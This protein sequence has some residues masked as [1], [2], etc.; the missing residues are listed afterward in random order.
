MASRL[1]I[2]ADPRYTSLTP[3]EESLLDQGLS[4]D[5]IIRGREEAKRLIKAPSQIP[6]VEAGLQGMR[7]GADSYVEPPPPTPGTLF[8]AVAPQIESTA[9]VVGA[10]ATAAASGL[11]KAYLER[12]GIDYAM[13]PAAGA[14]YVA[15]NVFQALAP[16]EYRK[17]VD[18]FQKE[19]RQSFKEQ[20][21][22]LIESSKKAQD[23]IAKLKDSPFKQWLAQ[24]VA[25]AASNA[26]NYA[27][28]LGGSLAAIATRSP[29][30]V[31]AVTKSLA[32]LPAAQ[33]YTSSY[34][35]AVNEGKDDEFAHDYALKQ[36]GLEYLFESTAP[37]ASSSILKTV[38]KKLG[39]EVLSEAGTEGLQQLTQRAILPNAAPE[40]A[41]EA[42]SQIGRAASGALFGAGPVVALTAPGESRV[43]AQRRAL[44]EADQK[45]ITDKIDAELGGLGVSD[46]AIRES[47][48]AATEL[49]A[50]ADAEV[51]A[52]V[53]GQ[54]KEQSEVTQ[55]R[56][57]EEL[58]EVVEAPL[59][60]PQT[61]P[62]IDISQER[63]DN[64]AVNEQVAP[65]EV[66]P[67]V[68]Q[69]P[70]NPAQ[71]VESDEAE[72]LTI[73]DRIGQPDLSQSERDELKNRLAFIVTGAAPVET[74]VDSTRQNDIDKL[75]A[76]LV[77]YEGNLKR[78]KMPEARAKW[79]A[80]IEATRS[81]LS[82]LIP[83]SGT[84]IPKVGRT[85]GVIN[86]QEQGQGSTQETVRSLPEEASTTSRIAEPPRPQDATALPEEVVSEEEVA[87]LR[88]EV[89]TSLAS[90]S[91]EERKNAIRSSLSSDKSTVSASPDIVILDED[92]YDTDAPATFNKEQDRG[93]FD[94]ATGKVYINSRIVPKEEAVA[95]ALHEIA[96]DYD[97][98]DKK[99]GR[100]SVDRLLGENNRQRIVKLVDTLASQGVAPVVKAKAR[101]V[102]AKDSREYLTYL[103][104]EV[105]MARDAGQS[106]PRRVMNVVK[107]IVASIKGNLIDRFGEGKIPFTERITE[108]DILRASRIMGESYTK[109]SPGKGDVMKS[110]GEITKANE[111]EIS[112]RGDDL[113]DDIAKGGWEGTLN[114]IV[115]RA[116]DGVGKAI[117]ETVAQRLR[118][119]ATAGFVFDIKVTPKD[120]RIS[121][122]ARGLSS[123]SA[124][125][126]GEA[127]RVSVLL[128]NPSNGEQ[129]GTNWET[130]THEL[131]HA[132]TQA[133]IALNP[134]GS[135]AKK[136]T[137]LFNDV[138]REFNNR[139]RSG[140]MTEFEK[141]VFNR[142][143]NALQSP[144]ELLTWGL[145]NK[146]MQEFL[147]SVKVEKRSLF[148]RL[149][150]IVADALGIRMSETTALAEVIAISDAILTEDIQPLI[151][152]ANER[153]LS[154]GRQEN[155]TGVPSWAL[156]LADGRKV[157][158]S[159]GGVALIEAKSVGGDRLILLA[160]PTGVTRVDIDRYRGDMLPSEKL[161]SVREIASGLRGKTASS[162]LKSRAR[163]APDKVQE[164]VLKPR[165]KEAI[166][167]TREDPDLIGVAE[168]FSDL[169]G[170]SSVRTKEDL[171][172]DSLKGKPRKV[173]EKVALE[174]GRLIT[175]TSGKQLEIKNIEETADSIFG[176]A[177][178]KASNKR[179]S[180]DKAMKREVKKADRPEV[181]RL[182]SAASSKNQE[183][184]L[185]ARETL[186]KRY[187]QVFAA[188]SS[189]RHAIRLNSIQYI[190]NI[191]S[192][193]KPLTRRD[194]SLIR[195]IQK[196]L[197]TY[198]SRNYRALSSD[199][200]ISK[201][202][203]GDM[204]K[205]VNARDMGKTLT[206]EQKELVSIFDDAV[207][208]L[209]DTTLALG[210]Y[211][212]STTDDKAY[213]QKKLAHTISLAETWLGNRAPLAPSGMTPEESD[214]YI[215][216]V[217]KMLAQEKKDLEKAGVYLDTLD[218]IA[219]NTAKEIV[220]IIAKSTPSA[221]A[222]EYRANAADMTTL[223]KKTG[224]T[225]PLRRLLG[226]LD[227]PI[228]QLETTLMLQSEL[229]STYKKQK[230][231]YEIGKEKGWFSDKPSDNAY[232]KQ[233]TGD[234]YGVLNGVWTTP[235]I[236]KQIAEPLAVMGTFGRLL[237][238]LN[239]M[240]KAITI[241]YNPINP[242]TNA[243][244][245]TVFTYTQNG[246]LPFNPLNPQRSLDALKKGMRA[247]YGQLN[248]EGK[249]E[250]DQYAEE[251]LSVAL[252]DQVN[253]AE[254]Q[255]EA[256]KA[257]RE[258]ILSGS[259]SINPFR[260]IDEFATWLNAQSDKH[261]VY[262]V[263]FL[264]QEFLRDYY[265]A[266]GQE[267][268]E[269]ILQRKAAERVKEANITVERAPPIV[270]K[271]ERSGFTRFL[272][273][274]I[275]T[276]RSQ[277]ASLVVAAKDMKD[278]ISDRN[279]GYDEASKLLMN[280]GFTRFTGTMTTLLFNQ[281]II[282]SALRIGS[283][284]AFLGALGGVGFALYG[285]MS[286]DD[287]EEKKKQAIVDMLRPAMPLDK[288]GK[289][290]S[291]FGKDEEGNHILVERDR[292]NPV[293]PFTAPV[294]SL[295]EGNWERVYEEVVGLAFSNA[296]TVRLLELAAVPL[297]KT[298]LDRNPIKI[299]TTPDWA[300]N[301]PELYSTILNASEETL[302][303]VGLSPETIRTGA[304]YLLRQLEPYTPR[305][306]ISNL[307]SMA[308]EGEGLDRTGKPEDALEALGAYIYRFNPEKVMQTTA[309]Y[310]Y[311]KIS[312][313]L[314]REIKET[315]IPQDASHDRMKALYIEKV[316][317][318]MEA[319]SS[320]LDSVNMARSSGM[321]DEA[322]KASLIDK[323]IQK[324]RAAALVNG[325]Y[326]DTI[327]TD[328]KWE[329]SKAEALKNTPERDKANVTRR[330]DALKKA[331]LEAQ[332][333]I[334]E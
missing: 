51:A 308:E 101:A 290:Y 213:P 47:V 67:P 130:V 16:D 217:N 301:N 317:E 32:V 86:G 136:L 182:L 113:N 91:V 10:G 77:T 297:N 255:Q 46:P 111:D 80:A 70:D 152:A 141:R 150:D 318:E 145:T 14:E 237:S 215:G 216:T 133:T 138:V 178:I 269:H 210:E 60:V 12:E 219:R 76:D 5:E 35:E 206:K 180:L 262:V 211:V 57:P 232:S 160:T 7:Q 330:F 193:G 65:I 264:E 276:H 134:E 23:E 275:E 102:A 212:E 174:A 203:I 129:S 30:T 125:G 64:A 187:P 306:A 40:G 148:S 302:K 153:G 34:F 272:P 197:D 94:P 19:G 191:L 312:K 236:W 208:E 28:L 294:K 221:F 278:A 198:I 99:V 48:V 273:Y 291:Y 159:E 201:T 188:F 87:S 226:E 79:T 127:T 192:S 149:L 167:Q 205:A 220:G 59:D 93:A 313:D 325:E 75:Q 179:A 289:D 322:I 135:A 190:D 123:M 45:A 229:L 173:A 194:V 319:Y 310:E 161:N 175:G 231:L 184:R 156:A 299:K 249:V 151:R 327:Y 328:R 267:I 18:D 316:R 298:L 209:K 293:D 2:Y 285:L 250:L 245:A 295:L 37:G 103:L 230:E 31:S 9:R 253:I 270:R 15:R 53:S 137:A 168:I 195:E 271:L 68:V 56:V 304:G 42:A 218:S 115:E 155:T 254:L 131:L 263:Y 303:R 176:L 100:A 4:L 17:S 324:D 214:T 204:E 95:V 132:A 300:K 239:S 124:A 284:G 282:R 1:N 252:G 238:K 84:T 69:K 71:P 279:N 332:Q 6:I 268:P 259:H 314:W 258:D 114:A 146:D 329:A 20:L 107:D 36:S 333:E 334:K 82:T 117:A 157:L 225:R 331:I 172:K 228:S 286:G 248:A 307:Q 62:E 233:I 96:H 261:A 44:I 177:A 26:V 90:L 326:V 52:L 22:A 49:A 274:F 41:Q 140:N 13:G 104:E 122:G 283:T 309:M 257:R 256:R 110:A 223:M 320:V 158:W 321:D 118:S 21:P 166:K 74:T 169:I 296:S 29:A 164:K 142:G 144:D 162:I 97:V 147:A 288:Q 27:P 189:F 85:T 119:L 81:N 88:S 224:I 170:E 183:T 242:I 185:Q 89:E 11:P 25:D 61:L 128:N 287:E 311:D 72:V 207:Q 240:S 50:K 92:N 106:V 33:A 235:D 277:I 243:I 199:P 305:P 202:W 163:P 83:I 227:N 63:V 54:R 281:F 98:N 323:G 260:K 234:S 200:K 120:Q 251:V 78:A 186:K 139:A 266:K 292:I 73:L 247:T 24:G 265:A 171:I 181:L 43:E 143:N 112:S 280:R 66:P 165:G 109:S 121:S 222:R 8:G 315:T 58:K 39:Y 246:Y 154:F 38:G 196:N 116:P 108:A 55:V 126:L 244:G 105:R 3:E 241:K